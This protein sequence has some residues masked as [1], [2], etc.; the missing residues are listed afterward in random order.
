MMPRSCTVCAHPERKA[1]DQAL[2]EKTPNRRIASQ[3]DVTERA[4]RNHK[5]N[6]LPAALSKA[7]EAG[8]LAEAEDLLEQ[9][10]SLHARTLAIL[11]AAEGS[12][13]HR[14]ALSAIREARSNL[15]LLAKLVGELDERPTV[16][17]LVS[18]EWLVVRGAVLDALAPYPEA[19]ACVSS[20]LLKLG[21]GS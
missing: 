4:V 21:D 8:E 10:R 11:E 7:R 3:H 5:A 9:V 16:N 14:T 19:R 18:P 20:K 6:H 1:I 2:V 13:Q 17:I 15:E 12:S